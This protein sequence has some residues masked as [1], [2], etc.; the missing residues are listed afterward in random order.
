MFALAAQLGKLPN[1]IYLEGHTDTKPYSN[2][3]GYT[4]WELSCDRAN[5]ARRLMQS[6]GV[7]A[8]QVVE[9]RGFA[10]MLPRDRADPLDSANRRTSVIVKY[11]GQ[12][13]SANDAKPGAAETGSSS[14]IVSEPANSSEA[15][16]PA[17]A[18]PSKDEKK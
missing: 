7:R 4:N 6:H 17:P 10:D 2:G 1:K 16:K 13:P 11:L 3:S 15:G 18:A 9:V 5:D 14:D 12:Q 8:D